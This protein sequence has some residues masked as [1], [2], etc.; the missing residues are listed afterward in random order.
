[1][2]TIIYQCDIC[3]SEEKVEYK[4]GETQIPLPAQ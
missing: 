3:K 2:K 4:A 1:M